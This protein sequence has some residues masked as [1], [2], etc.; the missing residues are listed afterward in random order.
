MSIKE[1]L[2]NL[3]VGE[4]VCFHEIAMFPLLS[5]EE[6]IVDYLTLDEALAANQISIKEVTERGSVPEL[7]VVNSATKP[8]LML[9]GEELL[10]AKQNRVPNLTILIPP[11]QTIVIPV[12]CVESG[13]WSSVSSEFSAACR[14]QYVSGRAKRMTQVSHSLN[15]N[16]E[17]CSDQGAV[18][19]DLE[20]KALRMNVDSDTNAMSD[21]FVKY[22]TDIEEFVK[23]LSSIPGQTGAVFCIRGQTAG[24]E[25]FDQAATFKK[26]LSK[27]VRSYA[28]EQL[29]KALYTEEKEL[30]S[31]CAN[32]LLAQAASCTEERYP[33]TGLGEDIRLK[34]QGVSGAG[35]EA[36]GRLI[37]LSVFPAQPESESSEPIRHG[38]LH[39]RR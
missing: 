37:Q 6:D 18:W 34:G 38:R 19:M 26:Q 16:D 20:D 8:V 9:D 35:L 1:A 36:L 22:D 14:Y 32:N 11:E 4:P 21:M 12:S 33:A 27:I 25:L 23:N 31:A 29:D 39:R 10:G 15:C 3:K 30:D 17:R 2:Q 13:R 28:I 7:K 5:E 24:L